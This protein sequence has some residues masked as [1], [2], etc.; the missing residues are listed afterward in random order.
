MKRYARK[1][2]HFCQ[3]FFF[4]FG[5][6]Y[7]VRALVPHQTGNLI[8]I[9]KELLQE[10]LAFCPFPNDLPDGADHPYPVHRLKVPFPVCIPPP[11][12]GYFELVSRLRDY[13]SR[14]VPPKVARTCQG[15]T[16]LRS[17]CFAICC[18]TLVSMLRW[19]EFCWME[20]KIITYIL[21]Y[22]ELLLKYIGSRALYICT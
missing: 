3:A 10:S 7:F 17:A 12:F 20:T 1:R 14:I 11:P 16:S 6:S 2:L 19:N 4:I 22:R 5:R 18:L 8:V 9:D 15:L 21:L 13:L